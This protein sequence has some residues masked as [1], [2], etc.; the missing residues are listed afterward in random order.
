MGS[1]GGPVAP[2]AD[3]QRQTM[4]RH[5]KEYQQWGFDARSSRDTSLGAMRAKMT[6]GGI[7]AGSE[8]WKTNLKRIETEYKGNIKGIESGVTRQILA[9][10]QK[11]KAKQVRSVAFMG[12]EDEVS[13]KDGKL[14]GSKEATPYEIASGLEEREAEAS[15]IESL[16]LEVYMTQ[17]FGMMESAAPTARE[18]ARNR[19]REAG[20]GG[21]TAQRTASAA[22]SGTATPWW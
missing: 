20:A 2:S 16:S 12:G 8:Q 10:W 21:S 17:E 4:E 22:A 9:D 13:Y 18:A 7:K 1:K 14:D 5:W 11:S 6:A 15:A 19:A 3:E